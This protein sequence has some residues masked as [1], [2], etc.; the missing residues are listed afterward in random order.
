MKSDGKWISI[1]PLLIKN[2]SFNYQ[3]QITAKITNKINKLVLTIE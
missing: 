3:P 2:I 1:S